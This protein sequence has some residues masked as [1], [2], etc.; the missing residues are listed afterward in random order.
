MLKRAK[1]RDHRE[2][3]DPNA[4]KQKSQ[5]K[6]AQASNQLTRSQ[7]TPYNKDVCFFCEEMAGYRD[8]L[9]S[10]MSA[11]QALYAAN[12]LSGKDELRVKLST[13]V[14]GTDAHAI[15]IKYHKKC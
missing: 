1:E 2:L 9:V 5:K 11:G 3:A 4:P 12:Q 7:T 8:T 6:Q 13:S 10:T 14:N 15:D